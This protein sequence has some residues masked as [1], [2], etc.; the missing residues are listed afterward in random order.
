M[1]SGKSR[2]GRL[3]A[4]R[5]NLE[6]IDLDS[7]FESRF[8]ISIADFFRKYDENAFRI[9]ERS[10]LQ[11][12]FE[13]DQVIISTGGGTP[14]FFDNME[15]IK[16]YGLSIYLKWTPFDLVVHLKQARKTRP[17]I[18]QL[19]ETD[20]LT[21]IE[22]HLYQR[23]SFYSRADLTILPGLVGQEQSLALILETVNRMMPV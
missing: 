13:F 1:G 9:I 20:L 23:E 14:C 10:L 11:E 22:T 16:R 4:D 2:F 18:S 21:G 3:L 15:Q 12:T 19:P 5:T 7:I 17:V 8:K 6:H